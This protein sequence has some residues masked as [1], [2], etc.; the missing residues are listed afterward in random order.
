MAAFVS[1]GSKYHISGSG[2][3]GWRDGSAGKSTLAALPEDPGSNSISHMVVYTT[4]VPVPGEL[5]T[6]LWAVH[7][8]CTDIHSGKHSCT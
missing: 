1:G 4:V 3:Q 8:S 7:T 5:L 6:F 2:S